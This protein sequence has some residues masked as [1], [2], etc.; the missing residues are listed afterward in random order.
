MLHIVLKYTMFHIVS[1]GSEAYVDVPVAMYLLSKSG[2]HVF[3]ASSRPPFKPSG[4]QIILQT[5]T[6]HI[7]SD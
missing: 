1:L 5:S 6:H 3:E 4:I 2:H 7:E